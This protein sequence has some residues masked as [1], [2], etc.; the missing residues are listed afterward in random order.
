MTKLQEL[1]RPI[2]TFLQIAYT[3]ERL[4]AL[5]A[6]AQQGKLAFDS[7]CCLLGCSNAPHSLLGKSERASSPNGGLL[8]HWEVRRLAGYPPSCANSHPAEIA[9]SKLPGTFDQRH[10][11]LIPVVKAEMRR[12]DRLKAQQAAQPA[13]VEVSV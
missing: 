4:A 5:L 10:H 3:D 1:K 2:R 8:H 7:C 6:H 9:F 13:Q 11:I 12:R